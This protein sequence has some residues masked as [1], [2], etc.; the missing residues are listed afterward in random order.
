MTHS[1]FFS[2]FFVVEDPVSKK[3]Y[4]GQLVNEFDDFGNLLRAEYKIDH[5]VI[6]YLEGLNEPSNFFWNRVNEPFC[7]NQSL[8]D[9]LQEAKITGWTTIPTTVLTHLG[10]KTIDNYFAVTVTGRTNPLDYLETDVIFKQFPGG[11]FPHFKGLYFDPKSW[12]GTDIFMER[13]DNDGKSSAFIYV[14]KKFVDAFKKNNVKN[15][16][17]VNFNDYET[18]CGMI[19]IGA[20]E[21]MKTKIDEKVKKASA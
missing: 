5:I 13:P 18:D 15:I 20:T 1:D 2:N 8:I 7:V 9:I 17:F 10:N 11:K 4:R 3:N 6:K 16:K 12:D 19:K 14:T 21:S